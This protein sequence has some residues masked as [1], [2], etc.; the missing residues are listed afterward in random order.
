[1]GNFR[2]QLYAFDWSNVC[3]ETNPD[4]SLFKFQNVFN[5]I[6]HE[7]IPLKN[8]A[9]SKTNPWFD[10]ELRLLQKL[11]R[12][13][14]YKHQRKSNTDS[15]PKY[16]RIKNHYERVIKTKKANYYKKLLQS[17]RNDVKMVWKTINEII[18]RSKMTSSPNCIEVDDAKLTNTQDIAN[19][20]NL[21]FSAIAKNLL[22]QNQPSQSSSTSSFT[23]F[24]NHSTFFINSIT[25]QEIKRII[26]T[27]K[28]KSFSGC[29]G[30]PSKLLRELPESIL[31]VLAH[32]FNQFFN[33]EKFSSRFELAKVVPVFRKGNSTDLNNYRSISLLNTF[34]KILEKAMHK[35]MLSFLNRN[36]A[37]SEFQFGFRINYSTPLACTC[38]INK[39]TKYFSA[40]KLALTAFPDLSKAFDTLDHCILLNKLYHYGFRGV[41]HSFLES[42]LYNRSQQVSIHDTLSTFKSITSGVPQGST[43]GPLL[44]LIYVNDLFLNTKFELLMYADDMT[45]IVPGKSRAEVIESANKELEIVSS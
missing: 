5:S 28:P 6:F 33:A 34:S 3:T 30:I 9:K 35:R 4:L 10:N 31:E 15:K 14:Y 12:K 8:E 45:I 2:D 16:S 17:Y 44:F 24:N 19:G 40:N 32:I 23:S 27:I 42:Y 26:Y 13:A 18:V 22:A 21:H 29:D 38:L 39:I 41:S 20:F 1:M 25:A 11:K 37:L 7:T 43:L 36:H